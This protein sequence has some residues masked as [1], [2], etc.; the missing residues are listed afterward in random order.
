M[1][2]KLLLLV[3]ILDWFFDYCKQFSR[4]VAFG[5]ADIVTTFAV[6]LGRITFDDFDCDES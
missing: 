6:I 1:V 5:F 4:S 2:E 3:Y